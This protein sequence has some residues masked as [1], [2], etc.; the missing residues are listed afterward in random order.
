MSDSEKLAEMTKV[1]EI[2]L[3]QWRV[4]REC[5]SNLPDLEEDNGMEGDLYRHC[6]QVLQDCG[7]WYVD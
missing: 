4:Y 1:L 3:R 2:A 6:K 7:E 5:Y